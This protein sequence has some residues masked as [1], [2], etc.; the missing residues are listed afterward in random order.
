MYMY[1]SIYTYSIIICPYSCC[2]WCREEINQ[3]ELLIIWVPAGGCPGEAGEAGCDA[4][5]DE[6]DEREREGD[7]A[8]VAVESV[9][10]A[11]GVPPA[12][13]VPPHGYRPHRSGAGRRRRLQVHREL[14]AQPT[15][16]HATSASDRDGGDDDST[17]RLDGS[18]G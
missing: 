5:G 12:G 18:H 8:P 13:L 10:A 9:E 14:H 1:I 15:G 3:D 6:R 2:M 17:V 16:T 7:G 4:E 11:D